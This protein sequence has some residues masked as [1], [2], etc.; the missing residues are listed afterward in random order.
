MKRYLIDVNVMLDLF[1]NRP[2][3]A[4]D[5]G[6]IWKARQ[7]GE[8]EAV[9][10]AFTLPTIYYVVR[11]QAHSQAALTAVRDC[12]ATLA[13]APVDETTLRTAGAMIGPD[14]EDNLQIACAIQAG[15]DAIITRDPRGF[16]AAP[17]AVI[18][19]ADLVASLSAPPGP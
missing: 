2:P 12:L 13:I 15:V 17:I 5:A 10:A 14:F 9:L 16:A 1:M 7:R 8:I 3:W 6:A 11:R 18:S 4:A 19:P